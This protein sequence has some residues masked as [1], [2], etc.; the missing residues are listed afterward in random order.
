M[1]AFD[2][3]IVGAGTAGAVIA[4][5]L[6]EDL[7]TKVL[8]IEAGPHFASIEQTPRDLLD[9]RAVSVDDHDWHYITQVTP[10][11]DFPY[12]RG[13]VSGGCSAVN[14][15]IS[16]RGLPQDFRAWAAAGNTG[17]DWEDI[18]PMYKRIEKIST[19]DMPLIT[20]VLER[21]QS[22]VLDLISIPQWSLRKNRH[23]RWLRLEPDHN[24]PDGYDGVGPI[25]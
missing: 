7:N 13:K 22:N 19:L 21:F 4:A 1:S 12:A 23:G 9:S 14:G 17:W 2:Y 11:R 5:R 25:R 3:I 8:L 10:G 18:L 6:T 15:V 16:L 24:H 20:A